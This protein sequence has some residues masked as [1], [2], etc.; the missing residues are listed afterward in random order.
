MTEDKFEEFLQKAAQSYNVPPAR[1]PR[2][3]MWGAIQ[4]QRAS[5]PRVIYGGGLPAR[6]SS[7]RRFGSKVWLG[8]AAAA[9]L[10]LVTGVGIGRWSASRN[11]P[12]SIA[13][14]NPTQT[15]SSTVAPDAPSTSAETGVDAGAAS[16]NQTAGS[17]RAA[18]SSGPSGRNGSADGGPASQRSRSA[19]HV[20]QSSLDFGSTNG[21]AA[22]RLGA[23]SPEQHP[24]VTGFARRKRS[25]A[26]SVAGRSRACTRADRPAI[27][28]K[29]A[30]G[31]RAD[32]EDLAARPCNDEAAHRDSRGIA[33]RQLRPLQ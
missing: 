11:A 29:H 26:S 7:V 19:P 8:A 32:R 17:G 27:A 10:F 30:A 28:R 12:T 20:V 16:P 9:A 14:V 2:D 5:G 6:E 18:S 4:A 25:A 15:G 13:A 33:A 31:S 24:S 23:R 3:D 1:T 21:R 22:R